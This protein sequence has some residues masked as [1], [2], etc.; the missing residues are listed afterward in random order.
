MNLFKKTGYYIHPH[1]TWLITLTTHK[2]F[3]IPDY[4]SVNKNLERESRK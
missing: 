2:S 4:Y 3:Q 1:S